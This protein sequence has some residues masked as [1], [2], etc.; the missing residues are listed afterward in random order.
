LVRFLVCMVRELAHELR[1]N[2]FS[3]ETR[4]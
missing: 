4:S 1:D 3:I 2:T